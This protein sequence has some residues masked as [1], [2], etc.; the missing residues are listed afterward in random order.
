[1]KPEQIARLQELR[2]CCGLPRYGREW[3]SWLLLGA[4]CNY[5]MDKLDGSIVRRLSHQYRH[6][7]AAMRK[8]RAMQE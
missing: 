3:V 2:K 7:I 5:K 4:E 8:N 6:Q 1:M